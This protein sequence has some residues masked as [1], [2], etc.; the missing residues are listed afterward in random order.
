MENCLLKICE[1][2]LF[3]EQ[4]RYMKKIILNSDGTNF[5]TRFIYIVAIT[6]TYD[7][8]PYNTEGKNAGSFLETSR[9]AH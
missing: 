3:T 9:Y 7:V 4:R 8:H 1:S 2:A 5:V 6:D